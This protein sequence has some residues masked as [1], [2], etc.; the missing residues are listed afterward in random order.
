MGLK[1]HT[2]KDQEFEAP[3]DEAVEEPIYD[4]VD[5]AGAI[6]V[7]LGQLAVKVQGTKLH[8][9]IVALQDE[10]ELL[11]ADIRKDAEGAAP[12]SSTTLSG[13]LYKA[14]VGAMPKKR[15]IVDPGK[16]FDLLSKGELL[17]IVSFKL[18]DLDDYLTKPQREEVIDTK[19]E[20]KRK[21]KVEA[22]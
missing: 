20:G 14:T 16:I 12:A 5:R 1:L 13:K 8:Q 10:L 17:K 2:K 21:F 4:K 3:A 9:Q 15:T 7:E 22:K 11:E 6:T 19:H 18:A